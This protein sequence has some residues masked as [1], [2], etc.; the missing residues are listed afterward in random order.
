MR[1]KI[2]RVFFLILVCFAIMAFIPGSSNAKKPIYLN[3][4]Y[5]FQERAIDLVS[6]MTP[7]EKQSQLG[8]TMPPIPR[9]GINYY[10]VWGEALH[11]VIGRNNNAGMTATSFPNSVA[12][13]SSWDPA[14][15][16]RETNFISD[17]A[18]GFNY[19]IIFTLT[20]WSPVIEP[21]R[22]PRWGRTGESFGE[23]PFLVS[24]IGRG[25]IQGLMGNDPTYL[26]AVPC[27]KHY[28]ANSSEFNRHNGSSDMDE[29]D[30]REFYLL[31][32]KTLIEKDNLPAIMTGYNSVNGVPNSASK[33]NIDTVA[34]RTYGL[35]GY[36]TGD[37]GAISDIFTGHHYAKNN[38]EAAAMGLKSGVD[39]D[40][41]SVYQTSA[42][43]ALKQG[44][45]TET[46]IDRALINIFTIRM[47]LG[48]F[49]PKDRVPYR[50]IKPGIINDPSHNDL[51]VEVATRTPVLLKNIVVAKTGKK[52]LPI[53]ADAVKKIAV[54]GPQSERV[55]L[56]PYS[57][58]P[59][60]SNRVT[61]LAGIKKYIEQNKL[62]AEVAFSIGGNTTKRC[63][64]F[65]PL[66]F[67]TITKGAVK[68][69]DATKFDAAARGII[70]AAR[71]GQAATLRGIKDG[72]W[73]S[74]NN[75]DITNID[76]IRF[77]L[78]ASS[79][80]GGIIEARIGSATGNLIAT[81]QVSGSQQTD[82]GGGFDGFA[83]TRTV[84][85]KAN[86]L[87]I[88]GPQTIVFV[89]RSS[90]VAAIDKETLALASSSDVVVMFVG[91]DNRTASEGS[92]RFCLFLPGNQYELIKAIAASN[93][94]TI[95]VMQSLGMV[96]VDQFKDNPNVAAILWT[97]F[98]GQAQGTAMAKILFGDVNPGGKT[99]A[100]WYKSLNDLP[101]FTD[102]NL[103]GGK[104]KNGRTYMY[105]NKDVSYEFGFGLSYTTFEYSNFTIS[106]ST[107]TPND[108]VTI[109]TDVRNTGDVEG[110]VVV[111]IYVR[112][113][114]SPASMERPIKRLRGFQRVT[115]PAGQIKTV[116]ID[117]DCADLWFWDPTTNRMTFDRGKYI[118]EIGA[119][120]QDIK[121][122]VEATMTGSFIP[123][124]KTVVV[125]GD[126]IVL[127]PGN[128]VNTSVTA[129]LTDDSFIS[130]KDA[131]V[132]YKST[133][134]AVAS[135]DEKG[136]ATAKSVG[137]A[138]IYASVTFN[139]KTVSDFYP[140]KVMPNVKPASI[141]ID[142]KP[143]I[144][145]TPLLQT[146]KP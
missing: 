73:T 60:T 144:L 89:Y 107:I 40:C 43:D 82:G 39:S 97:G 119:S 138:L 63:D 36:V 84:S 128:I 145:K 102:Y 5:S 141:T 33:Y 48:E 74:Y 9:L 35:K 108:K 112:T 56:G 6:R 85:A 81:A 26:K 37:C 52:P 69:F 21:V 67:A 115:I 72:D 16:K 17:E 27:G 146:S 95:V 65:T 38:A 121:G 77:S 100:T 50:G 54:I 2:A 134:P 62:K 86:T 71:P 31:P 94:N 133:N 30:M 20:Y 87:G 18:R 98:N 14:M 32:Y 70:A 124:L 106:K 68:E 116:Y 53:N 117:V 111:Q 113:P 7:E 51:A 24:Q 118:F 46:D 58:Q 137:T 129:S 57:G 61:P 123:V 110:D 140:V 44:L 66:S 143:E 49:D 47:K 99:N 3:T 132:T 13:G 114:D 80:D 75:V 105:F 120:S 25:F 19:N 142:G 1:I 96:E 42:L 8:N 101:E 88:T 12:V 4:S 135:V 139:G 64:F 76:S 126:R 45:I 109:T 22:D 93:S 41:G 131:Q 122:R 34:K 90:E 11:G 59:E 91:T 83:K 103:R 136:V 29:R 23:D 55:E 104:G 127:R 10:D 79:I 92:D 15:V 78:N 130:L 125:E 28:F